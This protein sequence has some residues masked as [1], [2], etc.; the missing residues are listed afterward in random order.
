MNGKQITERLA[1]GWS[2]RVVKTGNV[3][4]TRPIIQFRLIDP[5]D[6]SFYSITKFQAIRHLSDKQRERLGLY[7]SIIN[8]RNDPHFGRRVTFNR[9]AKDRCNSDAGYMEAFHDCARTSYTVI[10]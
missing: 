10:G 3:D 9:I 2:I 5:S 8:G 1:E 7:E 4:F 6:D